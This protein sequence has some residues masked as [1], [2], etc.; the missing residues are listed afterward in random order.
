MR[1]DDECSDDGT[2]APSAFARSAPVASA[3]TKGLRFS[4]AIEEILLGKQLHRL[5]WPGKDYILKTQGLLMLHKADGVLYALTV[6]DG[7]MEAED[8]AVVED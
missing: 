2:G 4:E 7:D 6:S 1:W 3:S 8:W 5:S